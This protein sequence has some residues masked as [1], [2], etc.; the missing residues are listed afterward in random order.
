[1]RALRTDRVIE[2]SKVIEETLNQAPVGHLGLSWKDQPYAVPLLFA[3]NGGNIYLHCSDSGMIM[4][5]LLNSSLQFETKT[6]YRACAHTSPYLMLF[7][8]IPV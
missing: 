7:W 1:M 8:D 5:F 6:T 2:Y 3:L 4:R